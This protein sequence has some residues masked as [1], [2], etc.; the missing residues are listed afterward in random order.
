[1]LWYHC[2]KK[3]KLWITFLT[4]IQYLIKLFHC[5][6]LQYSRSLI[7]PQSNREPPTFTAQK[8]FTCSLENFSFLSSLYPFLLEKKICASRRAREIESE[9]DCFFIYIYIFSGEVSEQ[10]FTVP[11][12]KNHSPH[13]SDILDRVGSTQLGH[14]PNSNTNLLIPWLRSYMLLCLS[15]R[16]AVMGVSSATLLSTSPFSHDS[17]LWANC[18]HYFRW[19]PPIAP[20]CLTRFLLGSKH[21]DQAL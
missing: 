11:T 6:S 7:E 18:S 20:M 10:F 4:K 8:P 14:P 19:F 12:P 3:K 1:M 2:Y 16:A 5:S 17:W 15:T 9:R 13:I 21:S